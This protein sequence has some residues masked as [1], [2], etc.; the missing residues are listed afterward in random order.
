MNE[1]VLTAHEGQVTTITLNRR[2]RHNSLTPDFLEA[3]L[4]V[5]AEIPETSRVVV[6]Q[7]NGRL[8]IGDTVGGS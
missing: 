1:R 2:E 3:I 4:L 6:L 8:G 5:W 7:A